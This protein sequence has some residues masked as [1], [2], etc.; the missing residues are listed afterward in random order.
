MLSQPISRQV[1]K[2]RS[3]YVRNLENKE[4]SSHLKTLKARG[5][6]EVILMV[7]HRKKVEPAWTLQR[8]GAGV[9][10]TEVREA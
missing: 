2:L 9:D 10:T 5:W 6:L 4:A 1:R 3:W 8:A 7:E